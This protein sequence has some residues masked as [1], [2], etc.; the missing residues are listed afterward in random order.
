MHTL[1]GEIET[2][3]LIA[4]VVWQLG[5]AH[6]WPRKGCT[7]CNGSGNFN[8]TTWLTGRAIRRICPKCNGESWSSRV[9]GPEI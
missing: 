7:R 4:L 6:R 9:G 1:A 2:V 3:L 5:R 8:S